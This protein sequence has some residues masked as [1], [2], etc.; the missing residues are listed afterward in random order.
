MDRFLKKIESLDGKNF[1]A[2]K[3]LKGKYNFPNFD[4]NFLRI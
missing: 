1:G 2:I 4:L 3:S